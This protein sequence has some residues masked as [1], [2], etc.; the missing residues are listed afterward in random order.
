MLLLSQMMASENIMGLCLILFC[1]LLL[2][3][4]TYICKSCGGGRATR[5]SAVHYDE[6]GKT[7][8]DEIDS[9]RAATILRW[10][11]G[12]TLVSQFLLLI[13]SNVLTTT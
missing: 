5:T 7:C 9:M 6:G 1:L 4:F 12:F 10:L 2:A 3:A 11:N 13:P 8:A